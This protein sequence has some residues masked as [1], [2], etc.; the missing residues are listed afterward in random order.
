[1]ITLAVDH[2]F[3]ALCPPLTPDEVEQLTANLLADGCREPLV[4]WA[5]PPHA[6]LC[7]RCRDKGREIALEESRALRLVLV[8]NPDEA[9]Q[10]RDQIEWTCPRC[11]YMEQQRWII[12][13]GHHRYDICQQHDLPFSLREVSRVT[14]REEAINWIIENQLGRRNLNVEQQ[15]YL[16]GRRRNLL[17]TSR[18]REAIPVES[19]IHDENLHDASFPVSGKALGKEYGVSEYTVIRDG[20]FAAALDLMSKHD[21]NIR[22]QVLSGQSPLT[23][24]EVIDAGK[25]LARDK[26]LAEPEPNWKQIAARQRR[27][28]TPPVEEWKKTSFEQTTLKCSSELNLYLRAIENAGGILAMAEPCPLR[29]QKV[30]VGTME[31]YLAELTRHYAELKREWTNPRTIDLPTEDHAHG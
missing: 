15:A 4:V 2:E 13:D 6:R 27:P 23:K 10:L 1:M 31:K 21:P 17:K 29:A 16:R 22:A 8:G 14:T 30:L 9:W 7:P 12:L 5:G 25:A 11:R 24:Q 18:G 28:S 19:P 20:Q 3:R 26:T